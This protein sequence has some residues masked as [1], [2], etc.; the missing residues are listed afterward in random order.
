[1]AGQKTLANRTGYELHVVLVVRKGDHPSET[2]GTVEITLAAGPDEKTGSDYS[3]QNISYGNDVD[4]YLNGFE[5]TMSGA[6]KEMV[7]RRVVAERGSKLDN[8]L[9]INDTLDFRYDGQNVLFSASNTDEVA[10]HT[11]EWTSQTET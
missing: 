1:M 10:N 6:G 4:I 5:A 3:V 11:W 9:N 2:A 7:Q 8:I